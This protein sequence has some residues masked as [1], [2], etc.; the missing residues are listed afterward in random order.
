MM[1]VT[2][3]ER[4]NSTPVVY[5]GINGTFMFVIRDVCGVCVCVCVCVC[6]RVCVCVCVLDRMFDAYRVIS[7]NYAKKCIRILIVCMCGLCECVRPCM[8]A[9]VCAC[10]RKCVW[11]ETPFRCIS[12]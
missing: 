8:H 6:V 5:P 1:A 9:C 7:C 4:Y 10:V 3:I 12:R 2:S 11:M